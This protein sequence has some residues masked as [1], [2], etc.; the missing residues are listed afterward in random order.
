ME[1]TDGRSVSRLTVTQS[2]SGAAATIMAE[3]PGRSAEPEDDRNK[4]V[5]SSGVFLCFFFEG[6]GG[7]GL[8]QEAPVS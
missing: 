4:G 8:D 7:R 3:Q 6:A 1:E 5:C 2:I